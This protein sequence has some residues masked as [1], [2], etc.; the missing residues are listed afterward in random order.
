MRWC[1]IQVVIEL[2]HVFAMIC[3]IVGKA[4]ETFLQNRV[5][6]IPQ[7]NRQTKALLIVT[8]ASDPVLA[9]AIRSTARMI[10]TEVFPRGAAARIVFSYCSPLPF[11]EIG[12]PA[13]PSQVWPP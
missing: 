5:M 1:R 7:S 2:L 3:L 6:A 12:P 4:E 10:V 13:S 8:D 9:P 11:T